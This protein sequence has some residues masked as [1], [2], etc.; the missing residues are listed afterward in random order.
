[1]SEIGKRAN[2]ALLII[3]IMAISPEPA[4]AYIDPGSGSYVIQVALASLFGFLFVLKSY[5]VSLKTMVSRMFSKSQQN[6]SA[7]QQSKTQ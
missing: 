1:M 3:G 6:E 7:T 4:Q 2:W 5:W